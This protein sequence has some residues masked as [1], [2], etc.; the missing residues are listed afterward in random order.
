[1]ILRQPLFLCNWWLRKGNLNV[2]GNYVADVVCRYDE[3]V[4]IGVLRFVMEN[5]PGGTGGHYCKVAGQAFGQDEYLFFLVFQ[6]LPAFR[7]ENKDAADDKLDKWLGFI[8]VFRVFFS[9]Y[10]VMIEQGFYQPFLFIDAEIDSCLNRYRLAVVKSIGMNV[11]LFGFDVDKC[12]VYPML[13]VVLVGHS[14]FDL[15][16]MI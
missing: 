11:H 16:V 1:M 8:L 7:I 13:F 4:V 10:E 6:N 12:E 14:L 9:M 3:F 5:S 2:V 15:F